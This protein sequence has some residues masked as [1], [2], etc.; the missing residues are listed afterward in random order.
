MHS[1]LTKKKRAIFG[2]LFIL[3]IIMFGVLALMFPYSGDDWDWG[4]PAGLARLDIFFKGYNGRYAGNLL[5]LALTRSKILDAVVMGIFLF[6]VCFLSYLY[7]EKKDLRIYLSSVLLLLLMPKSVF[8]QGVVW[9]SGFANYVPSIVITLFYLVLIKDLFKE[10]APEKYSVPLCVLTFILGFTGALFMEN[11]TIYNLFLSVFALAFSKIKFKK[12]NKIHWCFFASTV[13]GCIAMFQNSS[14]YAILSSGGDGYRSVGAGA[15][16]G[17]LKGIIDHL[18]IIFDYLFFKNFILCAVV[19]LTAGLIVVRFKTEKRALS[20]ISKLLYALN[21]V[22]LFVILF[23]DQLTPVFGTRKIIWFA[24]SGMWLATLVL[25]LLI[26]IKGLNNKFII[27][28]PLISSLVLIAP[29]VVLNP[30]GPRNFL[31][32]YPLLMVFTLSMAVYAFNGIKA[33]S[34]H[35][36]LTAVISLCL[37]FSCC[38]YLFTFA[39]IQEWDTKRNEFVQLQAENG[40]KTIIM[41]YLP[42]DHWE[43]WNANFPEKFLEGVYL[44]YYN[45]PLD[46]TIEYIDSSQFD[47]AVEEYINSN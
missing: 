12:I 36:A 26:C 45:L 38:Y 42:T 37:A 22:L 35:Y 23:K 1:Q 10:K 30:I 9:T 17:F 16:D 40:E 28:F 21:F 33:K 29:L 4:S 3:T 32:P 31:S 25:V 20:L 18:W 34:V 24:A 46:T 39:E 2:V 43:I 27:L 5:V 11:V 44:N 47:K 41:C 13:L 15:S 7:C 6:L 8:E 19:T 14:Y